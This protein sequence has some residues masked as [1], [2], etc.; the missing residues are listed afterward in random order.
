[1]YDLQEQHTL[2]LF[3][4]TMQIPTQ[5]PQHNKTWRNKIQG[6]NNIKK[7]NKVGLF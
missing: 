2:G 7:P 5:K 6:E 3:Q 1:M 4:N